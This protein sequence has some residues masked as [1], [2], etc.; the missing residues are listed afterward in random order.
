MAAQPIPQEHKSEAGS[1]FC[2]DPKCRYCADLRRMMTQIRN[3]NVSKGVSR[4]NAFSA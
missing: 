2:S 1:P 3:D 4:D